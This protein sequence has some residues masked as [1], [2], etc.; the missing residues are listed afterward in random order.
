MRA[1]LSH[2]SS[3]CFSWKTCYH[4]CPATAATCKHFERAGMAIRPQYD[5]Y[6]E[7][8]AYTY[9]PLTEA[10]H[11]G[12]SQPTKSQRGWTPN[13]RALLGEATGSESKL[14]FPVV[15]RSEQIDCG[16]ET[17]AESAPRQ[18]GRRW[19]EAVK[20]CVYYF[21]V[22]FQVRSLEGG[23]GLRRRIGVSVFCQ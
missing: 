13:A 19:C 23:S 12:R 3:P 22:G 10:L 18:R 21:T 9:D 7:I 8:K 6:P 1:R 15:D 5:G 4:S 16:W 11:F 2:L 17:A 20:T 14:G